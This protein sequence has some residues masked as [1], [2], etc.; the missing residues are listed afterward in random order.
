MNDLKFAVRQLVK[1]PGFT[2]VVVLTLAI[3][4]GANLTIV[5]VVDA[6]LVRSLPFNEPDR[7]AIVY[8]SYPGAGVE[9]V[10]GSLPNYFD[11]RDAMEAFESVSIFQESSVIVNEGGQ[12]RRVPTMRVSPE[13]FS[14]L[15][16]P[17]ALGQPFTEEHLAYRADE[18]AIL[19]DEFWRS[20]F[21]A[22]AE[23]I[24]RTFDNDGA[25]IAVLGVLPRGFRFLS[26]QVQ[27][28]R[29]ASHAPDD[30][31]PTNRHGGDWNMIARLA[32]GVTWEVAQSQM[33]VLNARLAADD[34]IAD[35]VTK[36]GYRTRVV[37]LRDDHV[38]QVKRTLLLLQAG[39]ALL[40]VIGVVNLANLLLIRANARAQE[41]AVR[42][43]LG[44]GRWQ[45]ARGVMVEIMTLVT[46]AAV[47]GLLL[48]ASGLRLISMLGAEQLP[49]GAA[50][51][52]DGRLVLA[53]FLGIG[54]KLCLVGIGF[55]VAGAWAVG[56]AMKS[57][58][59][60]VGTFPPGIVMLATLTLVGI[61]SVAILIPSR[62]AARINPMEALRSE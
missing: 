23:V 14:T 2:A 35:A 37:S 32:P 12:A 34:P 16:V 50:I 33:D 29:P 38:R 40:L 5:A 51:R 44:A 30:R 17:L 19:T 24:G 15:G 31:L 26:S 58:L 55:G 13:F 39:V 53:Q 25:R 41:S 3:C 43:A 7:L 21:N 20:Q 52:F 22:D 6:I 28:F 8:N 61:V 9:R 49:L 62:R 11:R 46:G 45:I 1:N 54:A 42:Q 4:I 36:A 59:Y 10:S 47:V 18:V 57:L 48:G 60:G 27:F 56:R